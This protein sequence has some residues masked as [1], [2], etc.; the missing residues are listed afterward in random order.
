MTEEPEE[1]LEQDRVA[2]P[3]RDEE[4]CAKWRSNSSMVTPPASTGT[5]R[6]SRKAV[7]SQVQQN[8]GMS[9]R[10]MPGARML[11][12]VTMMLIEASTEEMPSRWMAKIR[13]SIDMPT[14]SESGG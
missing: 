9:I 5:T 4:A 11:N 3:F 8:I 2:A 12:R 7:T 14:C 6:I 13:K 10:P 1:V